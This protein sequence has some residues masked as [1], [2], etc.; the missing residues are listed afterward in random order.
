MA[1]TIGIDLGTTN[2]AAGFSD[3]GVV[4]LI[5]NRRG[6][7]LT[8]SV[9]GYDAHGRIVVGETAGN[10]ALSAPDRTVFHAKRL[11][12]ERTAVAMGPRALSPEEISAAILSS[13]RDDARAFLA[14]AS[15]DYA[16]ITVPAH[17]DDRQR[18]AT[19]EAGLLA[20]FREVRLLN[21]P[22]AAALP[23]AARDVRHERMVVFDFGGGTLDVTCM[24]RDGSEF[25]VT[26]TSGDGRLGG[27]DIDTILFDRLSRE[28]ES[29]VGRDVSQD[30]AF[31]QV[32]RTMAETVKIELSEL[33]QTTVTIPFL[34]AERGAVH[35]SFELTR[36]E[37]E[38]S[39]APIVQRAME[40]TEKALHDAGFHRD[41]FQTLILAG[42]SSRIPVIRRL[43]A[44]RYPVPLASMIN[45]EEVVATGATLL[46]AS[47]ENGAFSLHDVVSGTLAL[48]L[49]DG[50]CVPVIHRNQ[51]VPA[52]RTRIFTTVADGQAEAEIHL[53]Q[54]DSSR[55][56]KN[57]SL[58]KFVLN[59]LRETTRGE[60]RIEVT[61]AVSGE[62]VVTVH[63]GEQQAGVSGAMTARTRPSELRQPVVGDATAYLQSLVRR[64]RHL[65]D[66]ASAG[67]AA[68]L[69]EMVAMAEDV[70]DSAMLDDT[71]TVLE[72]LIME[73]ASRA[74]LRSSGGGG[75][76]A[77]EG[78][79]R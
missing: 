7:L 16:V 24:E 11:M 10:Q 53:V 49:A 51:T 26:A 56:E 14:P 12:G 27:A 2:S 63:A 29:Q 67:L 77:R 58:G 18:T 57:R 5:P 65:M 74:A 21:E 60:P 15:P 45:P 23:Y 50:T 30:P 33:E 4:H 25:F 35:I 34:A 62:G 38:D 75:G 19:V 44:E 43:L 64:G 68:E 47:R 37:L 20:G 71:I 76:G 69:G 40:L 48:E 78:R 54:G 9:V 46:A 42:G 31:R 32:L 41:G 8:P 61:V 59:G 79:T 1:M 70:T 39:V 17:F 3:D 36:E 72:T 22:T 66:H 55:A 6:K 13:L 52:E 73:I 28:V